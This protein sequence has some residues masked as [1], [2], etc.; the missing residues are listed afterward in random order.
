MPYSIHFY[1]DQLLEG[2]SNIAPIPPIPRILY[3]RFGRARINGLEVNAQDAI[4]ASSCKSVEGLADWTQIWRWE[5]DFPIADQSLM[6]G[7]GVLSLHRMSRVIGMLDIRPGTDWLFRLDQITA[8]PN[9]V[10]DPHKHPGP[11]IRCMVEGTF[12]VNQDVESFRGINPG[13]PWWECGE[14]PVVA[15]GSR[16]MHARFLR[17]M[18]LPV[19]VAGQTD[20]I[21]NKVGQ[22]NKKRGRHR[23]LIDQLFTAH[24]GGNS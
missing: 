21:Q 8:P 6:S 11:G 5:V 12:N 17:G 10:T 14:Q 20:T 19:R 9:R 23:L 13:D 16:T 15:W 7:E 1:Q 24:G 4:Y 3:V 22:P 2:S 18:V